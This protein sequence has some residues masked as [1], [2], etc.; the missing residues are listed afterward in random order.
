MTVTERI[1]CTIYTEIVPR[2]TL[3]L[4]DSNKIMI[5]EITSD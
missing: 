3:L 5:L 1:R 2:E 4:K